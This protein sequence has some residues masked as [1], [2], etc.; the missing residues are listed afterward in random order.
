MGNDRAKCRR[1][2]RARKVLKNI[3]K[4]QDFFHGT[5]EF[6]T[7]LAHRQRRS[8]SEIAKF[9]ELP[10][11]L[12][13]TKKLQTRIPIVKGVIFLR[14]DTMTKNV[15]VRCSRGTL[16]GP[17][18]LRLG[19]RSRGRCRPRRIRVY[20]CR[21]RCSWVTP[22]LTR[23]RIIPLCVNNFMKASAVPGIP[24]LSG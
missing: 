8:K 11:N 21:R 5:R 18:R 19:S 23:S 2:S 10:G 12:L 14:N 6:C 3:S 13:V 16:R 7:I 22:A 15:D 24:H 20:R 4:D 1:V 17:I 9:K